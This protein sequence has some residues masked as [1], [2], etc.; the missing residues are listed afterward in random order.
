VHEWD[1]NPL[2]DQGNLHTH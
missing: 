1:S 2:P